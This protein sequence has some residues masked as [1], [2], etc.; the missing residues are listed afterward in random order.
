[1]RR[2]L[3]LAVLLLAALSSATSRSQAVFVAASPNPVNAMATAP[4]F[5][6][7]S[8]SL[9][10]PGSPLRG[11]VALS[12]SA[13]SARPIVSVRLQA[14]PASGG[15]YAELCTATSPPYGCNWD[16]TALADGVY[17]LRAVALDASGYSQASAVTARR[18]DNTPP[19]VTLADPGTPLTGTATLAATA[20]DAGAGVA[21]VAFAYRTSP[22]G[23]WTTACT[24]TS[25][26][27]SC[28][29][30]TAGVADG[31]YDVRATATDLAGNSAASTVS[32]RRVDNTAP[33]TPTIN[34]VA[35]SLKGTVTLGGTGADA[36]SGMASMRF[37]YKPSAGST[38]STACTDTTPPSPFSCAWDSTT[39]ADGSYDFR[40]LGTD[41]AGNTATSAAVSARVVD[42]TG[43]ATTLTSPGMFRTSTTVNA[44]SSDATGIQSVAIQYSAAGASAWTTICTDTT[45]PYSCAWNASARA[46]GPY[47]LRAVSLDT[48]GN[49]STS[50]TV[51]AYVNNTGPTGTDVQ[52]A[53]GGVNNR[54][55]AG[56]TVV[57]TYSAQILPSSILAGWNGT[58]TPI[59]VRVGNAGTTDSM[60]FYDS[61]NTT[62]L[63][64]L[65]SGT[66]LTISIDYVNGPTVFNATMAQS[67]A[68]VT[69]TIG[70][71]VSGTVVSKPKGTNPMVW[72]TS[73]AALGMTGKP[74]F[75]TTVTESGVAD[76][77][78]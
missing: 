30:S 70:S 63:G 2:L 39:V 37:E 65:G 57:F 74:V 78:F 73:S 64:L 29:W 72:Q 16:T 62:A 75:P 53:N 49:Q 5:N 67:G 52:G 48:L 1:M 19:A 36:G 11:A 55:D 69:V 71:L 34:A 21:S 35:S 18:V 51:S 76:N 26:P 28:A 6:T 50:A 46:D 77:D 45:A 17:D 42:N 61:A 15:G 20:S 44:T 7:V 10:D 8:V 56:D 14:A 23:S 58:A 43:P 9:A 13:S 38:W 27:Y 47:D 68:T 32:A 25:A 4:V 40:A 12:A 33:A 66:A 59:K 60:E 41:A 54:L 3:L 24:D 31:V 22:G